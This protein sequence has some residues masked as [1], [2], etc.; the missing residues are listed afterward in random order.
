[1][2]TITFINKAPV[3]GLNFNPGLE[4]V[5]DASGTVSQRTKNLFEITNNDAGPFNGF[6]VQLTS[7]ANEG[8]G[9]FAYTN[10]IPTAGK[11]DGITVKAPDGTIILQVTKG[12]N[13]FGDQDLVDFH[14]RIF[15][16]NAPTPDS[17]VFEALNNLLNKDNVVEGTDIADHATGFGF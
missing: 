13:G 11:I 3:A 1:M 2:A 7:S 17:A 4:E 6:K 12:T 5:L 9:D 15:N 16:P 10:G 8:A 14:A